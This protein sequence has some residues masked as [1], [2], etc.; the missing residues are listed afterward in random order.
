MASHSDDT[1]SVLTTTLVWRLTDEKETRSGP[2]TCSNVSGTFFL[3][4]NK[5]HTKLI[6]QRLNIDAEK[7]TTTH[8]IRAYG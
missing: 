3:H 5:E 2:I 1:L 4:S 7:D 6:I 8:R